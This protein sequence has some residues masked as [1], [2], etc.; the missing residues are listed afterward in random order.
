MSSRRRRRLNRVWKRRLEE[1]AA[2]LVRL[3]EFASSAGPTVGEAQ[4]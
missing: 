3:G 2:G 1:T 4:G